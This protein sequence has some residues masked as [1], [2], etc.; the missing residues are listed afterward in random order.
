MKRKPKTER[1]KLIEALD[2]ASKEV[3]RTRDGNVC[4]HC[5]KWVEGSARHVSHV[6]P[7]SA[8][9]KLRWDP[10]NMKILCYHCHINWWHK[11]PM[12]AYEWF[13]TTF[14]ERWEYLQVNRGTH[15][16]SIQELEDFLASLTGLA[17]P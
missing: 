17:K 2:K 3:V 14:P 16:F 8:G 6:I 7:V 1:K 13:S 10:L 5:E 15:K 11:N 4:Q 12:E 9:M